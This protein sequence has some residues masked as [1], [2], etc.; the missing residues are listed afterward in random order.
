MLANYSRIRLMT[1]RHETSAGVSSGAIGYIIETYN[2]GAYEVEFSATDGTT[3]AQLVLEENEIQ[4]AEL[5][6]H[7]QPVRDDMESR[8]DQAASIMK[9]EYDFEKMTGRKN[10][11]A[12]KLKQQITIKIETDIL[13]YFQSRAKETGIPYQQLINLY[14][15]DCVISNR[16][17]VLTWV[18]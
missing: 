18:S 16:K 12:P 13:E 7:Q 11:Y 14:L 17:P 5:P 4:L 6:T 2:D 1:S 10:P 15:R 8:L 3:I 9:K